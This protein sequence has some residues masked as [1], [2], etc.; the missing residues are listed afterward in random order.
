MVN[1]LGRR[2]PAPEIHICSLCNSEY[3]AYYEGS[4]ICGNCI[5]KKARQEKYAKEKA[6]KLSKIHETEQ[7]LNIDPELI[8]DTDYDVLQ[9]IEIVP[10]R[11][12][13]DCHKRTNNFRCPECYKKWAIKN[14]VPLD[15]QYLNGIDE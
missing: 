13:H 1:D 6:R 4:C 9:E 8:D 3:T 2:L 11:L 15:N 10:N 14:H 5:R 12:C 7:L